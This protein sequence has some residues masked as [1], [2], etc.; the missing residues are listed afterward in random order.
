MIVGAPQASV[1]KGFAESRTD[2]IVASDGVLNDEFGGDVSISGSLVLVGAWDGDTSTSGAAYLF[3][4]DF[5]DWVEELI[6]LPE[7][8]YG[9]SEDNFS[10]GLALSGGTA[11]IGSPLDE[12]PEAGGGHCTFSPTCRS[13]MNRID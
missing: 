12:A 5:A 4:R 11:F 13:V 9:D 6:L 10:Q 1:G 3:R 8:I 2:T 7:A